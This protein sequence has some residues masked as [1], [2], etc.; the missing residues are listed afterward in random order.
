[1]ITLVHGT[2]PRGFKHKCRNIMRRLVGLE[3]EPL[4]FESGSRF[5]KELER[6]LR[7][8][9][10]DCE[11]RRLCWGGANSVVARD[12][13]AQKLARVL[14][15]DLKPIDATPIVIAH[16]HGGNVAL[17]A[18]THLEADASRVRIVTLATPFL[19]IFVQEPLRGPK[20]LTLWVALWAAI[21]GIFAAIFMMIL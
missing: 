3:P 1:M 19:R 7:D 4:W 16:S 14:K 13:G 21:A 15:D 8:A 17:R 11:I 12:E 18:M 9:S 10:L 2:W 6:S 5:R 20:L